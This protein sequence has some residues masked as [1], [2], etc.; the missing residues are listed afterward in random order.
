MNQRITV[1]DIRIGKEEKNIILEV[2][3]NNRISEDK[4]VF[5]FEK[6]WSKFIGT[7]YCILV[8]SGTSALIAGL[9]ALLYDD[10]FPRIKKGT[11]VI[12]TPT[13][14][15]ATSN[16]I[17]LVGMEPAYVDVDP[18]NFSILPEQ[19]EKIFEESDNPD[20]YSIILPVHL[21]GYPCDMDRINAIAKKYNLTVFE[22]AS[23]AHGSK[24]KNKIVG[25]LSTLASY[26]FY[27]AHN[28]QAGEMGAVVTNDSEIFRLIK[29]IK[30]NGRLCD[31]P[32]C[33]R[34]FGYC[35]YEDK[36][37]DSDNDPRF[38]HDIIGY[39]FKTME[40]PAALGLIQLK[41][42]DEI[43][44]KRLKNVKMLNKGLKKFDNILQLP[45]YSDDVSYLAYPI[46][47]KNNKEINRKILRKKL[48]KNGIESRAFF[49]CIPTQQPAYNY[50]KEK[51]NDK[52]PNAEYLG[53]NA[54]YIGCH[55][56][57][58]DKDITYII[59]TFEK[60]F[61]ETA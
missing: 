15:I 2:L 32:V 51:Y 18:L 60:I 8:N 50:L 26:S 39:N 48:E 52:L 57:L 10:R 59:E 11:K 29:K 5:K 43:I 46:V 34:R 4:K 58:T 37:I 54:F 19:I 1:G 9:T 44:K 17:K 55:Q 13:T 41:K 14:Y 27:I 36:N 25:N 49:P 33:T 56:Y 61:K 30:A 42:I 24:Y 53:E 12:T 22:D 47:L 23:E 38:L 28:I 35:K 3:E 6:E 31:C 21:M 7:K 16:A 40:F 20:E 45:I